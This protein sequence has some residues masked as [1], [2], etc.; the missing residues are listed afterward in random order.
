MDNDLPI[1]QQNASLRVADSQ[2]WKWWMWQKI[3]TP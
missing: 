3:L 1:C 2:A